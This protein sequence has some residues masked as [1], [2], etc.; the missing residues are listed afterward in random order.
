MKTTDLTFQLGGYG[1]KDHHPDQHE[2]VYITS[3][4]NVLI[5][6]NDGG[7]YKTLDIILY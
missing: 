5:N 3:D 4:P 1:H 7:I 2:I 6:G